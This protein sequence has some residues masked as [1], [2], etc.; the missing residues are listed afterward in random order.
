MLAKPGGS[1]GKGFAVAVV[2]GAESAV[3]TGAATLAGAGNAR[4]P[5][6][7]GLM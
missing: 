2:A 5:L 1:N 4:G 7:W 3:A 6:K